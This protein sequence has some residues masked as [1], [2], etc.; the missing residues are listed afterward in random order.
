MDSVGQTGDALQ[1]IVKLIENVD[2]LVSEFATS[3]QEQAKGLQNISTAAGNMNQATQQNMAAIEE[4]N[5]A[6]RALKTEMDQLAHLIG[7]FDVG[8]PIGAAATANAGSRIHAA[9]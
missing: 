7:Q 4:S 2:Q 9:A 8:T 6:T 5:T 1:R 3:T